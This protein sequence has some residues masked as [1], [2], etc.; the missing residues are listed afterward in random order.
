MTARKGRDMLLKFGAGGAGGA[1]AGL[2]ETTLRVNN[3]TV[4]VTTKDSGGYR[5]LL[6][7]AGVRSLTITANGTAETQATYETLE[8]QSLA[9]TAATFYLTWGDGDAIEGTFQVSSFE[10]AGGYN[11]AQTFSLTLESSGP[12]TYTAA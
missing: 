2:R 4:D 7:G 11:D 12:W 6:A 10:M 8:G 9:D 1:V 3:E 5:T